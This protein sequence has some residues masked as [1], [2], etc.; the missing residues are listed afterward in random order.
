MEVRTIVHDNGG[1]PDVRL[2]FGENLRQALRVVEVRLHLVVLS[3]RELLLGRPRH[4][5]HLVASL[6]EHGRDL[7]SEPLAGA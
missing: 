5:G 3:A 4:D 1:D 2:D 7:R 6:G